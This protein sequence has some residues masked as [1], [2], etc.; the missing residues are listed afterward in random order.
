[1]FEFHQGGMLHM[2]G[3]DLQKR[4]FVVMRLA[5]IFP[6][7]LDRFPD[8]KRQVERFVKYYYDSLLTMAIKN[9]V[10]EISAIGDMRN[11]SMSRNF[12]LSL[13]RELLDSTLPH[14]PLTTGDV[15]LVNLPWTFSAALA[16]VKPFVDDR[17]V[18]R[19]V[20]LSKKQVPQEI[21]CDLSVI[22]EAYGGEMTNLSAIPDRVWSPLVVKKQR[23]EA[24]QTDAVAKSTKQKFTKAVAVEW[25]RTNLLGL[26]TLL[27]VF[28]LV[29]EHLVIPLTYVASM[30]NAVV[31]GTLYAFSYFVRD[32]RE[33]VVENAKS[34]VLH[35]SLVVSDFTVHHP[36][37]SE[38]HTRYAFRVT[39]VET[40]RSWMI[41]RRYSDFRLLKK[42]LESASF[43]V[44]ASK[45]FPKKKFLDSSAC[46]ERR[47]GLEDFVR[48][49][50]G[51]KQ[52]TYGELVGFRPTRHFFDLHHHFAAASSS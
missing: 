40:Q 25:I 9:G 7:E 50:V 17:V 15:Y 10:N 12:S 3:Y 41:K 44:D 30:Q 52:L 5:K 36:N 32:L 35:D 42:S 20:T 21:Q 18:G 48:N 4:P 23:E 37:E 22:E 33:F 39:Q 31:L 14:Y 46:E 49:L 16:I 24:P 43:H 47:E 34:C 27:I 11:W 19:V 45:S 38:N 8:S 1:M 13:F 6:A 28:F 26:W 29:I 51:G 2:T